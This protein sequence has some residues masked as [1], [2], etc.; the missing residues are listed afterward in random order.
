MV[1]QPRIT[2]STDRRSSNLS[3]VNLNSVDFCYVTD[4]WR[5][6]NYPADGL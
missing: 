4:E 6:G 1:N 3:E 5:T 2:V